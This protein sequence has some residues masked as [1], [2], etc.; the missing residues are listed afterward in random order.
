MV[1]G[2]GSGI[3]AWIKCFNVCMRMIQEQSRARVARAE[4]ASTAK[5]VRFYGTDSQL[6][7]FT[8]PLYIY[9]SCFPVVGVYERVECCYF[10]V[11]AIYMYMYMYMRYSTCTC[12]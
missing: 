9:A 11:L 2:V 3:F 12:R 10:T 8:E 7:K 6:H 1:N 5:F 4:H